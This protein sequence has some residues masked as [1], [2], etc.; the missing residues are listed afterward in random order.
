[1]V[2]YSSDLV[3][4]PVPAN[5]LF[6]LTPKMTHILIALAGSLSMLHWQILFLLALE[7]RKCYF[8]PYG[9]KSSVII[10]YFPSVW[11][12]M[13]YH[14]LLFSV[15]EDG[16]LKPY[17]GIHYFLVLNAF[18]ISAKSDIS[19][20]YWSHAIIPICAYTRNTE[21][22]LL[23]PH[24]QSNCLSRREDIHCKEALF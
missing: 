16:H 1:M 7:M 5:L 19:D 23:V 24:S 14:N 18:H 20:N 4:V 15:P 17:T 22:L 21:S 8:H 10:R 12:E 11:M 2:C 6:T 13:K 9:R 3:N